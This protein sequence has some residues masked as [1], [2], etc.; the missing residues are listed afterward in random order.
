MFSH[1]ISRAEKESFL[2][3]YNVRKGNVEA[4]EKSFWNEELSLHTLDVVSAGCGIAA[5]S[6]GHTTTRGASRPPLLPPPPQ[7]VAENAVHRQR[8]LDWEFRSDAV[9]HG[10]QMEKMLVPFVAKMA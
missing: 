10:K 9:A 5:P 1:R 6:G 2:H 4:A 3:D 8:K 7:T